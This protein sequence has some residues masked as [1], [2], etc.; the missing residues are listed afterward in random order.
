MFHLVCSAYILNKTTELENSVHLLHTE[1]NN[2]II[3]YCFK[4]QCGRRFFAS[5]YNTIEQLNK[6]LTSCD[7]LLLTDCGCAAS[8]G[9]MLAI[10]CGF[11]VNLVCYK[12]E[13]LLVAG[14]YIDV[15]LRLICNC[16]GFF[17]LHFVRCLHLLQIT[18]IL[19]IWVIKYRMNHVARISVTK[20][21]TAM[22]LYNNAAR[23]DTAQQLVRY[24][25]YLRL[26]YQRHVHTT[27]K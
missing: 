23:D 11:L 18:D 17:H 13:L 22:A 27:V 9:L 15:S 2:T 19:V 20:P 4:E 6:V 10:T 24:I 7:Q 14:F 5:M 3:K 12:P 8:R 1:L 21:R 25:F 26:A 16:F